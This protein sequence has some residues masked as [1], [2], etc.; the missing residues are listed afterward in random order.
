MHIVATQ[1]YAHQVSWHNYPYLVWEESH[2]ILLLLL[3]DDGSAS[4]GESDLTS[5]I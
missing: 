3:K 4:L 5:N 2:G 1:I